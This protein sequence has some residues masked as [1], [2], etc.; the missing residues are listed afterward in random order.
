[1]E[2]ER[3][4]VRLPNVRMAVVNG[5]GGEGGGDAFAA[6]GEEKSIADFL[7]R[8]EEEEDGNNMDLDL[9]S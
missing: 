2:A 4:R 1:M 8:S 5:S 7:E 3:E 9:V 6:S